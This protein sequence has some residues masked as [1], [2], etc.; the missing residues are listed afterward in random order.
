VKTFVIDPIS[1][2][3]SDVTGRSSPKRSRPHAKK[4]VRCGVTQTAI[5][6]LRF[7]TSKRRLRT[8]CMASSSSRSSACAA[9]PK[10][11]TSA[12]PKHHSPQRA[13]LQ[14]AHGAGV[15]GDDVTLPSGGT[16]QSG[17]HLLGKRSKRV[18]GKY[19]NTIANFA[20]RQ[21][22]S[23]FRNLVSDNSKPYIRRQ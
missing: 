21:G 15:T 2:T 19:R 11:L 16:A 8:C 12:M 6:T 7:S 1:N 14:A 10:L 13:V 5:P 9:G 18:T 4:R 3:V 17:R 23:E 22:S 20:R